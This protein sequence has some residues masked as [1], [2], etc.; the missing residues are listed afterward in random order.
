MQFFYNE[1][2][3][4]LQQE[5]C[6]ILFKNKRVQDFPVGSGLK[7]KPANAGDTGLIP[8][9]GRSHMPQGNSA[10]APQLLSLCLRAEEPQLL[11]PEHSTAHAPRRE[12]PLQ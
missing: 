12:R 8:G 3:L 9:P 10:R 5:K 1:Y 2:V 4:L 7:N 11:E 6:S